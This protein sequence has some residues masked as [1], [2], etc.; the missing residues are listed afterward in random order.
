MHTGPDRDRIFQTVSDQ[1]TSTNQLKWWGEG[2]LKN[3]TEAL[4]I[5]QQLRPHLS[6]ETFPE[7]LWRHAQCVRRGVRSSL[8]LSSWQELTKDWTSV[9]GVDRIKGIKGMSKHLEPASEEV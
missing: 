9:R 8:R 6:P 1:Q 4:N 5:A 3:A 2:N 7:P